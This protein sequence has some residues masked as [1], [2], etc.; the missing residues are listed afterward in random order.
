MQTNNNSWGVVPQPAEEPESESGFDH[1]TKN[2]A[3]PATGETTERQPAWRPGDDKPGQE[4]YEKQQAGE[5]PNDA[6]AGGR[7]I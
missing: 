1:S 4:V 3:E 2:D 5:V 7:G 6:E